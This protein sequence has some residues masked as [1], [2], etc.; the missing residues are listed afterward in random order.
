MD[1]FLEERKMKPEN[2]EEL[3]SV[4]T[5]FKNNRKRMNYAQN[6]ELR[7]PIGSGVTEAACKTLVK[8]R[9]CKGGSRWEEKS[10]DIVL[11]IRSLHQTPGRWDQFWSKYSQFGCQLAA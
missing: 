9:M 1:A 2:R 3:E 5:Y 6:L 8:Q 11:S 10:A 7:I 4:V